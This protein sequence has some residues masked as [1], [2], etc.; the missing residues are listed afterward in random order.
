LALWLAPLC[1]LFLG[2]VAR[3][4]LDPEVG[5][6]YHLRVV[7]GIGEHRLLTPV[8]REQVERELRDS[9]QA[10]FG[11]LAVVEVTTKHPRLKEVL[12]DGLGQA[13]EAWKDVDGV[14]THFV[15]INYVNGGYEV[16]ARQHDGLTGQASATIRRVLL[17]DSERELVARTA[18][19]LVDEDFGVVGTITG[20]SGDTV[21]VTLRG[22]G[23]GVPLDHWVKEGDVFVV[24]ALTGGGKRA[25]LVQWVVLRAQRGPENGVCTCEAFYRPKDTPLID[26]PGMD[27]YR[28]LKLTT[29]HG[30][31]RMQL[32]QAN[33]KA[34]VAVPTQHIDVRHQGFTG[35]DR[36]LVQGATDPD[37][38]FNTDKD[39]DHGVYDN[40]AFVSVITGNTQLAKVPVPIVDANTVRIPISL[41]QTEALNLTLRRDLWQG[42]AYTNLRTLVV[43]FQDMD[44]LLRERKND[45]ALKRAK[46]GLTG[47]D[48]ALPRLKQER[49]KL[50][51]DAKGYR[52]STAGGD[53]ALAQL[54]TGRKR[55]QDLV[56]RLEEA[57]GKGDDPKAQELQSKVSQAQVLEDRA[58]FG[59]ALELYKQV[60][61]SGVDSPELKR[62]YER[63]KAQWD[64]KSDKHRAARD[65][66]YD[67][68]PD[69]DPL[70]GMLGQL[71]E[72]H[73]ALMTC[74]A[75][76][77]TLSPQKLLAAAAA[78]AAT[79]QERLNGLSDTSEEDRAT[80]KTIVEVAD[81]LNKLIK[82]TKEYLDKSAGEG[83]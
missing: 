23:L 25:T 24:A 6:P 57:A 2:G 46:E 71:E 82:E 19:L 31:L 53:Q 65:F 83:K 32:V 16:Q 15:L 58:E 5:Q 51:Q 72:A 40:L 75:V 4:A 59:K 62:K 47:V 63:L 61:D 55:L 17:A 37:G 43:L 9:L 28:C 76:G 48:E 54:E 78:H 42:D 27:G 50:L 81:G 36:T 44:Q 1:C 45:V 12:R 73:K 41:E 69:L 10:A 21:Q 34:V 68:W 35:E 77:D 60:L 33:P 52:L 13:F 8:F 66:I 79:L 22:S 80:A 70:R 64:I 29:T 49:E 20:R 11:D 14:K 7:L 30:P 39:P 67:T 18:A 26:R 3:A 38:F 56:P 74:E